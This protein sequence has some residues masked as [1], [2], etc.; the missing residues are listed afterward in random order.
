MD[1]ML[2][3]KPENSDEFKPYNEFKYKFSDPEQIEEIIVPTNPS[4]T[5]FDQFTQIICFKSYHLK[6]II[7]NDVF[8]LSKYHMRVQSYGIFSGCGTPKCMDLSGI[9][10]H[11]I[12][13][14]KYIC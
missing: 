12:R 2:L 13:K 4:K 5:I 3:V 10:T 8:D 14:T 1:C 7:W 6:K 11:S 9:K